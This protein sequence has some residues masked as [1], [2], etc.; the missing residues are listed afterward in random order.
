MV[1][2]TSTAAMITVTLRI[3]ATTPVTTTPVTVSGTARGPPSLA[4]VTRTTWRARR[5]TNRSARRKLGES[6]RRACSASG[7]DTGTISPGVPAAART[8][9]ELLDRMERNLA[10]HV[11]YLHPALPG[12]TVTTG[13][14]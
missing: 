14:D 9:A 8:P 4:E 1:R 11:S 6:R 10:E 12:A 7:M 5:A 13:D 2:A 3:T